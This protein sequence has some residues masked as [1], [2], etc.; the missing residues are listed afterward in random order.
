MKTKFSP[1]VIGAFVLGA[2]ALIIISLLA[3]GGVN[4]FSKPQRF[5]VYFEESIHG[6]DLGSPVKLNGVRV[7]RVV[8]L[9][10]RYDEATNKSVVAVVCEFSKN[11][12]TDAQGHIIDVSSRNEL[13]ELIDHGLR[14]QLGFLG[15]ATGLL[16]VE[17]DF[18]DPKDYPA[19]NH[20]TEIRY[21]VVP[22]VKS[23]ISE[24]QASVIDILANVQKVDFAGLSEQLKSLL[25]ATHKQVDGLDLPGMVAQWK[26]TGAAVETV[27]NA[28]EIRQTFANLNA[29]V[30]DLRTV[31]AKLDTQVMP[32]GKELTATLA[33]AKA[34]L[35]SFNAAANDTRRFI[36]AQGGLGDEVA[37]TL[38]QLGE[39]ADSVQRLAD[40]L[41]RN[42]NALIAGKK[43]RP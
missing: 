30:T 32:A 25:V 18:R 29:A 7:G 12:L 2:F 31:L 17:L 36:A 40:Y 5:V 34:T 9:N 23:A 33:Q 15:F 8:D 39:A 11:M 14:A 24:V 3:F 21:A 41:E 37:H 13:Q 38:E 22:S 10:I 35:E 26:K 19:D 42:P 43:L 16:F 28:P 27:A 1:A 6:L 20:E 4:F